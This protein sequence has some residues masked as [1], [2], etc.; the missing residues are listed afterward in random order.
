MTT[1]YTWNKN[2]IDFT[3]VAQKL[4]ETNLNQHWE[5]CTRYENLNQIGFQYS[6]VSEEWIEYISYGLGSYVLHVY[7]Y[8]NYINGWFISKID[9]RM[10]TWK[11]DFSDELVDPL[12]EVRSEIA[13]QLD[14]ASLEDSLKAGRPSNH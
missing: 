7:L 8:R 3:K 10:N 13:S 9:L 11:S 6:S 4:T 12:A 2:I 14:L 5:V 1:A